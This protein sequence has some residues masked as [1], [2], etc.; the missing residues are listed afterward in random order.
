[1][2]G[3]SAIVNAN[4]WNASEGYEVTAA[5]SMRMVVDLAD[6]D[7][8]TWINQTGVSGHPTDDHYA[9]QVDDWVEG[10]QRPWPFSEAAVRD[11]DPDV[12][13]LRPRAPPRAEPEVGE[14]V[15]G[16]DGVD[17]LVVRLAGQ[18]R[19]VGTEQLL[20]VQQDDDGHA[21]PPSRQRLVVAPAAL[22]HPR[23]G[24]VDR[25]ARREHEVGQGDG[26]RP[27]GVPLRVGGVVPVEVEVGQRDGQQHPDAVRA[28][29]PR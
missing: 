2:P 8:S 28:P 19:L 23:P 21:G 5:P 11:T 14:P 18:R 13:T 17:R 16:D 15:S 27:E 24:P 25:E 26:V 9:D 20:R 6:L 4:A 7:A 1:M 22:A 3:G 12:L 10:R 29:A